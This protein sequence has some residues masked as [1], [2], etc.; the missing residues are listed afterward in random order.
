MTIDSSNG[1]IINSRDVYIHDCIFGNMIFRRDEKSLLLSLTKSWP[2]ECKYSIIYFQVI[3][4]EMTSCDFWGADSRVLD[5]E[6]VPN[7]ILIPKLFSQRKE[8]YSN[9]SLKEQQDYI[10]TVLTFISGDTLRIA[11]EKIIIEE[12]SI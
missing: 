7:G 10:E 1:Q 8:E 9:C 11:C 5:F 12:K 4:F 6:Y 3:G 2:V